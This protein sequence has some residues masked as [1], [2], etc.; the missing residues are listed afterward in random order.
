MWTARDSVNGYSDLAC[1]AQDLQLCLELL[2]VEPEGS[3][4]G[5]AGNGAVL[6]SQLSPWLCGVR[7]SCVLFL[8]DF[9]LSLMSQA[10]C[11]VALLFAEEI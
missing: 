2:L 10:V 5:K 3:Q 8:D 11:F 1:L 4:A 6:G 9:Q 7:G